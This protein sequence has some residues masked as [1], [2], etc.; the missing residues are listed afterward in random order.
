MNL[1]IGQGLALWISKGVWGRVIQ[2]FYREGRIE[3]ARMSP[4][5]SMV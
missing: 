2:R 4:G 5:L 1:C 3:Y